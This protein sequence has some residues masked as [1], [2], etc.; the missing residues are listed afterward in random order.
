LTSA[1]SNAPFGMRREA[2][3]SERLYTAI[4]RRIRRARTAYGMTQDALATRIEASRTTITNIE[5]GTQA[6][7]VHQ[8]WSIAE[9]LGVSVIDLL[10]EKSEVATD[11]RIKGVSAPRTF[12][13]LRAL[14]TD[15]TEATDG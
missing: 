10:P 6:A 2:P 11:A 8:L 3:E 5:K 4:G 14:Q 12:D 9:V 13:I 1:L 15:T 7:T